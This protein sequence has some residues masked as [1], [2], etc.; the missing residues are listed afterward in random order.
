MGTC[1]P[2]KSLSRQSLAGLRPVYARVFAAPLKKAAVWAAK[3]DL[4]GVVTPGRAKVRH[5]LEAPSHNDH[6]RLP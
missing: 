2:H 5:E 6:N 4:A 1:R 3:G